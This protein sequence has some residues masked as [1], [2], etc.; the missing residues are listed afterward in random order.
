MSEEN[1]EATLYDARLEL[2]HDAHDIPA[3]P[4]EGQF[5]FVGW[6]GTEVSR[7]KE[8][9]IY[10]VDFVKKSATFMN[11]FW[12][13]PCRSIINI[14]KVHSLEMCHCHWYHGCWMAGIPMCHSEFH[15]KG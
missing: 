13:Y 14:K 10:L 11:T 8:R 3:I 1:K 5:L 6:E 2:Q 9:E 7:R 4:H 15:K 12:R